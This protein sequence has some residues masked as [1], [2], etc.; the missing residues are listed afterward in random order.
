MK[1]LIVLGIL[2]IIL[3]LS[4]FANAGSRRLLGL[5]EVQVFESTTG[6][7]YFGSDQIKFGT[8]SLTF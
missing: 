4:F 8:D 5:G 6:Y 1:K 3:G 2:F 7:L